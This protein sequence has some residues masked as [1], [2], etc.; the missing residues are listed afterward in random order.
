MKLP[1]LKSPFAGLPDGR[2]QMPA[3]PVR[4]TLQPEEALLLYVSLENL[5]DALDKAQPGARRDELIEALT[6]INGRL[7]DRLEVKFDEGAA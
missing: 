6:E 1:V 5:L 4:L 2:I 3:K 7:L